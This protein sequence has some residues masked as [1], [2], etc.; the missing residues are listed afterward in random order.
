[1][2]VPML[3]LF[4]SVALA[5]FT[6]CFFGWRKGYLFTKPLLVPLLLCL[7]LLSANR[8]SPLVVLALLCGFVGDVVLELPHKA[9]DPTRP[10]PPLLIG[11]SAFLLGH[12][13]YIA[14]F[15]GQ[16][17][18]YPVVETLLLAV[19]AATLFLLVLRSLLSRMGNM[20]LPGVAYL[21]VLMVMVFFAALSGLTLPTP[22]RIL[23]ALLFLLSDYI[24][25][26]SILVQK[27]RYTDLIVMFTYLCAQFSLVCSVLTL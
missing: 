9:K 1:M 11:L 19:C 20:L 8:V 14:L 27:G 25:A 4:L 2:N 7:Y 6:T 15:A 13:F 5:H 18:A 12:V 10:N 23:G 16:M 22:P 24:L 3:V 21:A 17:T 26:R